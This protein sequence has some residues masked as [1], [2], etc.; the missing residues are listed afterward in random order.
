VRLATPTITVFMDDQPL[1]LAVTL[2]VECRD[3]GDGW[4]IAARKLNG[5]PAYPVKSIE[6]TAWPTG[7]HGHTYDVRGWHTAEERRDWLAWL[8]KQ[9]LNAVRVSYGEP[10]EK[11]VT[12]SEACEQQWQIDRDTDAETAAERKRELSEKR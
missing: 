3:D 10:F 6:L 7:K 9:N 2:E 5:E 1:P 12:L 4:E 8:L 11:T